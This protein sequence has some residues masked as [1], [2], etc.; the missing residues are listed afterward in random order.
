MKGLRRG[1][2]GFEAPAA[3]S[4]GPLFDE[5]A[6]PHFVWFPGFG[7]RHPGEAAPT[8]AGD[9]PYFN[10]RYAAGTGGF[11]RRG[12]PGGGFPDAGRGAGS[13]R[14]GQPAGGGTDRPAR[15]WEWV[16][17]GWLPA[18]GPASPAPGGAAGAPTGP[19]RGGPSGSGL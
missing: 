2:G 7:K 14:N 1:P 16:Y 11:G 13:E 4:D 8:I 3:A 5:S 18:D 19:D 17:S 15:L 10:R 6:L 12:G 9:R